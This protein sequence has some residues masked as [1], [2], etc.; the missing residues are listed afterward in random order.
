MPPLSSPRR[1]PPQRPPRPVKDV[2]DLRYRRLKRRIPNPVTSTEANGYRAGLTP[3]NLKKFL[4]KGQQSTDLS[5][6]GKPSLPEF[7][8]RAPR[9]PVTTSATGLLGSDMRSRPQLERA[10]DAQPSVEDP[11]S[12]R[13]GLMPL[14]HTTHPAPEGLRNIG[15]AQWGMGIPVKG[16]EQRLTGRWW[17][18]HRSAAPSTVVRP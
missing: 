16:R 2:G 1:G 7:G 15:D 5:P 12:T 3:G 18:G 4:A 13:G 14:G 6:P 11:A 17:T 10:Q 9:G 8:C